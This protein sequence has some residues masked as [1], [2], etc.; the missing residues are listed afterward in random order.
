M[1]T[2]AQ[3]H[4]HAHSL[5]LSLPR[6]PLQADMYT[7]HG[8]GTNQGWMLSTA[9]EIRSGAGPLCVCVCLSPSVS[10]CVSVCR[11]C[12]LSLSRPLDIFVPSSAQC[13]SMRT[14]RPSC[15]LHSTTTADS[16]CLDVS[17]SQ[18]PAPVR[19]EH[20][21]GV[22][23]HLSFPS[24]TYTHTHAQTHTH[25]CTHSLS[26][27]LSLSLFSHGPS[28]SSPLPLLFF[29]FFFLGSETWVSSLLT[30]QRQSGV[31]A[32]GGHHQAHW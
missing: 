31:E 24:I 12:T 8:Q 29:S 32:R 26:L 3:T 28:P 13:K 30:E 27:S 15:P 21:H 23:T 20:C 5:S 19:I 1:C 11:C 6:P 4:V 22:G 25:T 18:F 9:G 17:S 7:C 10:V 16:L 14:K 2:A